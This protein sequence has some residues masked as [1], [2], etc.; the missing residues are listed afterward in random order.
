MQLSKLISKYALVFGYMFFCTYLKSQPPANDLK[1]SLFKYC[2]ANFKLIDDDL[3]TLS[4]ENKHLSALSTDN[5]FYKKPNREVN[6]PLLLVGFNKTP[7]TSKKNHSKF[8]KITPNTLERDSIQ[9]RDLLP[10]AF[11]LGY[12][13]NMNK[14]F[15]KPDSTNFHDA[16]SIEAGIGKYYYQ[17]DDRILPSEWILGGGGIGIEYRQLFDNDKNKLLDTSFQRNFKK[18]YLN[19]R[20]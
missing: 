8:V 20:A 14:Y 16:W 5:Y 15:P 12:N 19:I 18:V 11:W 7:S 6:N 9:F 4:I 2:S 13:Y 17:R 3:S 1:Y 10:D